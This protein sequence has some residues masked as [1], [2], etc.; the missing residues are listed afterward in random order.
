MSLLLVYVP[1]AVAAAVFQQLEVDYCLQRPRQDMW[2]TR[3]Q[4]VP[5]VRMY[6]VND[7]GGCMTSSSRLLKQVWQVLPHAG[8]MHAVAHVLVQQMR[9]TCNDMRSKCLWCACTA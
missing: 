1:A 7:A 4:Q 5:V 9:R 2:P 3:A 6:G 8:V